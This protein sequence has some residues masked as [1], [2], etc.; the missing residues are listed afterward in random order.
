MDYMQEAAG[1]EASYRAAAVRFWGEAGAYAYDAYARL[2]AEL[3]ADLPEHLPIVIGITAYGRCLGLTRG[4]WEH[5]PR[6]TLPPEVFRG[7]TAA[8]ARRC[9]RGGTRR[10]DD[11]LTHEMLHVWL[12][13]T[14]RKAN[15]DSADWYEAVRRLSPAVLGHE[16]A[17]RR[18]PGRKSVRIPNPAYRPG[19]GI[20]KTLVRKQRVTA[21]VTHADVATWPQS[22]RPATYDWGQPIDC[23]SY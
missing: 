20:P 4:A 23:P 2:R 7:T 3:Y 21:A 12:I 8:N 16:L 15:H 6:I 17:A 10:V 1:Q 9:T 18:D 14:G 19:A 11:A 22:F 13:I 5:G